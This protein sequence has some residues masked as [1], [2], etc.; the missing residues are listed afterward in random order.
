M[1]FGTPAF[2][3]GYGYQGLNA[4]VSE[5]A[6]QTLTCSLSTLTYRLFVL[7]HGGISQDR[8][9]MKPIYQTTLCCVTSDRM[10]KTITVLERVADVDFAGCSENGGCS[11]CRR[12]VAGDDQGPSANTA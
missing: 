12:G 9:D 6:Q 7:N 10:E 11:R 1:H 2:A 8:A 3:H 5:L 4:Q